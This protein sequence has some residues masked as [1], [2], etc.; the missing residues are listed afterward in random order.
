ML[1]LDGR[2]TREHDGQGLQ[3]TSKNSHCVVGRS[4]WGGDGGGRF[5]PEPHRQRRRT[6]E[7]GASSARRRGRRQEYRV[8]VDDTLRGVVHV[9]PAR[10]DAATRVVDALRPPSDLRVR[11]A[12]HLVR[13][14]HGH[15]ARRAV[16]HTHPPVV[17]V[18]GSRHS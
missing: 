5:T 10:D 7:A 17:E 2:R 12:V 13:V 18:P 4:P 11:V 14:R 6:E 16:V 8:G 9:E 15:L 1:S 3:E